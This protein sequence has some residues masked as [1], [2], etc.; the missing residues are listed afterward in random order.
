M[1]NQINSKV[2][3]IRRE[4]IPSLTKVVVDGVEHQLGLL[5]DFRKNELLQKYI[6]ENSRLAVSWVH[7]NPGETLDPHQHPIDSMIIVAAGQGRITGD[8]EAEIK[9]GDILFVHRGSKHGFVGSAPNGY[10]ALSIQFEESGLYENPENA[11]VKFAGNKES[12]YSLKGLNQK[13]EE[14]MTEHKK[15][16]I[17]DLVFSGAMANPAKRGRLLDAI[18]VWSNC[19]QKI[20]MSRYVYSSEASYFNLAKEHLNEEFGHNVN[21]EK[22]RKGELIPIWDPLLEATSTWFNSK[23]LNYSDAERTVLVHLVLEGASNVFHKVADPIMQSYKE[24]DHFSVHNEEDP[25]HMEM[26]YKLLE[27]LDENTYKQLYKVLK[28]GW[29]MF[30]LLSERMAELS[31]Q[32]G[33]ETKN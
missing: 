2:I 28:E 10:W 6:P 3:H 16:K 33:K 5:K 8:L 26:G 14:Y 29:D 21:L 20:I 18:Q 31:E 17:F 13:N 25:G 9:D 1:S 4:D 15:N 32:A 30:N 7:L 11:L 23:M 22:S 27:N 12:K 24:T 19:F